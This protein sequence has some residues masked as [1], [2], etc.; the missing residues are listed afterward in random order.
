MK[1]NGLLEKEYPLPPLQEGKLFHSLEGW[2]EIVTTLPAAEC[3]HRLF[4]A[5]VRRSPEALAVSCGSVQMSYRQLNEQAN[6]VAHRLR[7]LGV[8]PE[9]RVGICM[10]RC[11]KNVIGLLGILKAGG[12]YVPLDPEYP[13]ERLAFMLSD[14]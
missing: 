1:T 5:Q 4:E 2:D 9:T 6:R 7:K 8:G 3:V 11:A 13:G 14:A 12:A 10:E